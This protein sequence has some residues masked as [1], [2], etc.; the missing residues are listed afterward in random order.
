MAYRVKLKPRAEK[1]LNNLPQ[2]DYYRVMA[3]LASLTVNPFSGKKLAGEYKG[4]YAIRVWPYRI[5]YRIY[6]K[7]LTILVIRIGQ[8][9]GI[10]K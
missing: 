8:R 6:K 7:D 3:V 10:Y 9:Q 2:T 4:Y 5:I 1:E